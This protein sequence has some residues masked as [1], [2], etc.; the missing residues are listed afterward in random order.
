MVE[1]CNVRE[2]ADLARVHGEAVCA[3][4]EGFPA[5]AD[6]CSPGVAV[7]RAGEVGCA[8]GGVELGEGL[9]DEGCDGGEGEALAWG[10]AAWVDCEEG[11]FIYDHGAKGDGS[12]GED[13]EAFS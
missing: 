12:E 3:E 11:G 2:D 9:V 4:D 7:R 5:D 1:F 10:E 13:A 6:V 8:A